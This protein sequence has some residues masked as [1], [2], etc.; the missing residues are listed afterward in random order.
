M[1]DRTLPLY[2]ELPYYEKLGKLRR[3]DGVGKPAEITE[4]ILGALGA[5][6]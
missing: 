1:S 6:R 4:R 3:V 5:T 2:R